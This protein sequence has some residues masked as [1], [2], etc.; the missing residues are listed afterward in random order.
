MYTCLQKLRAFALVKYVSKTRV[1]C[2]CVLAFFYI[3]NISNKYNN[4]NRKKAINPKT[5]ALFTKCVRA[6]TKNI[7]LHILVKRVL[8][9]ALF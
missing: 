3:H 9:A 8:S 5:N 7:F 6:H 2:V 1:I 4:N